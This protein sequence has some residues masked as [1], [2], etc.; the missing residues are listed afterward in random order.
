[1]S[2]LHILLLFLLAVLSNCGNVVIG[3]GNRV[4]GDGNCIKNGDGNT[5]RGNGNTLSDSY[6]NQILGDLNAFFM[7]NG[8][9]LQGNRYYYQN[10]MQMGQNGQGQR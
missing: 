1:M 6:R 3:D 10:G 5:V 4:H 2:S 8:M 7:T 9:N